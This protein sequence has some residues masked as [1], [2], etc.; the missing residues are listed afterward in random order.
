MAHS[1]GSTDLLLGIKKMYWKKMSSVSSTLL[2]PSPVLPDS[3]ASIIR[4]LVASHLLNHLPFVQSLYGT[5]HKAS[6]HQSSLPH[7]WRTKKLKLRKDVQNL[8]VFLPKPATH[9][10]RVHTIQAFHIARPRKNY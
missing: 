8:L 10:T 6:Q 7:A 4:T 3:L 5:V 2:V 1:F 9:H